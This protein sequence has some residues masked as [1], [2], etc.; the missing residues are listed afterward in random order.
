MRR[1]MPSYDLNLKDPQTILR[2]LVCLIEASKNKEVE[3][4][5]QDYDGMDKARVLVIDYNRKKG[6]IS[7]RVTAD[8][9]A[10]VAVQPEAHS[11]TQPP[12]TAPLERA[13]TEATASA[14]RTHVPTDE[15]LADLEEKSRQ[16][17]NLARL[18]E[19]GKAPLRIRTQN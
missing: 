19:E 18:E 6:V 3:F 13:R 5:A 4:W 17:Q 10:A 12:Q 15:E 14:K 7:L 9:G 16:N 2:I 11:W 8:N 1:N